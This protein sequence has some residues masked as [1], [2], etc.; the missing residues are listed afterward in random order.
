MVKVNEVEVN[1]LQL[2]YYMS[3]LSLVASSRIDP[4]TCNDDQY[5]DDAIQRVLQ[6]EQVLGKIK[7]AIKQ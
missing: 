5:I 4:Y 6:V 1:V 3:E 7:L 2:A